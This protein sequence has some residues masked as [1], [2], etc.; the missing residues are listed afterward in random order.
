[1]HLSTIGRSWKWPP[2]LTAI[3]KSRICPKR[4][5]PAYAHGH[6]QAWGVSKWRG[7]FSSARR[8]QWYTRFRSNFTFWNPLSPKNMWHAKKTI[9]WT[10]ICLTKVYKFS[11]EH[12]LTRCIFYVLVLKKHYWIVMIILLLLLTIISIHENEQYICWIIN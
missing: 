7:R 9:I 8:E 4:T 3:K 10:I 5:T 11:L 1:M 6:D 12:F 2:P